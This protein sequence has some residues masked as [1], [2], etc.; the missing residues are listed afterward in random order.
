MLELNLTTV[1]QNYLYGKSRLL[2]LNS[3]RLLGNGE[4]GRIYAIMLPS[5]DFL[6]PH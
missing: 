2:K 1:T 6:V 4:G 3:Q 5:S